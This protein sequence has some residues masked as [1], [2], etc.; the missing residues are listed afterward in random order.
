M[1]LLRAFAVWFVIIAVGAVHG[2]L[3]GLL[4]APLVG[5]LPARQMGVPIG[6]LFVFAVAYVCIG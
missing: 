3:R 2:V 4:L 5:D 1:L 6:S